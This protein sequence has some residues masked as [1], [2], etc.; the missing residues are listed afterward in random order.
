M[1]NEEIEKLKKKIE[2]DPLSKLFVPLAEEYKKKG[3]VDAAIDLLLNALEKRPDYTSARV[4]LGKIYLDKAMLPEARDEF[5]K[6]IELVPDNLLA[7]KRLADIYHKKGEFDRVVEE[8]QIILK[9]HP[10]D[11]NAKELM[12]Q[13]T[14][15]SEVNHSEESMDVPEKS[16]AVSHIEKTKETPVYE[17]PEEVSSSEL[18]IEIPDKLKPVSERPISKELK[19]FQEIME[20]G[21]E[22]TST[23]ETFIQNR[24]TTDRIPD[25]Q[26]DTEEIPEDR[27]RIQEDKIIVSMPTETMADIF[28]NQG[29]YDKAMEIYQEILSSEPG[30]KRII[31]RQEELEMLIRIKAKKDKANH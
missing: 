22:E 30:N 5:E 12:L 21:S 17:I 4:A 23:Q 7:H 8:C 19:E 1:T 11:E 6:V 13:I 28:I 2:K 24:D 3:M 9:L 25:V 18:G 15:G 27:D 14:A 29:L 20:K 31:Q 10:N 16:P 26:A